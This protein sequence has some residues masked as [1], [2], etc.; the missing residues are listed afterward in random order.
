MFDYPIS[1]T[2]GSKTLDVNNTNTKRFVK[3]KETFTVLS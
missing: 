3:A 2:Q 1:F